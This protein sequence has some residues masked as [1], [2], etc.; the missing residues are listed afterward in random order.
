MG[1]IKAIWCV[2]HILFG[3]LSQRRRKKYTFLQLDAIATWKSRPT[4][5]VTVFVFMHKVLM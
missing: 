1:C 3:I 2:G 5:Y 4:T